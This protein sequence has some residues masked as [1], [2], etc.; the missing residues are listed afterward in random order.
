MIAAPREAPQPQF[1]VYSRNVPASELGYCGRPG[2]SSAG[3]IFAS[4]PPEFWARQGFFHPSDREMWISRGV[5][6]PPEK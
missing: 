4:Q 5:Y 3:E 2:P 6:V 1:G